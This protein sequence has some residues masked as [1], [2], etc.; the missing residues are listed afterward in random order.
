MD[1]FDRL[2]ENKVVE[3]SGM[4]RGC[5]EESYAG[6]LVR[7]LKYPSLIG[8][9]LK[10]YCAKVADKLKEMLLN[11]DSENANL[12]SESDQMELIFQIFKLLVIGGPLNQNDANITRYFE[13]TKKVYKDLLSVFKSSDTQEIK[14]A[15]S[16]FRIVSFEGV[17]LHGSSE[18]CA[19]LMIVNVDPVKKTVLLLK[20]TFVSFW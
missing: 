8:I 11:S 1:F 3:P 2:R 19:N 6:I 7:K 14:V 13:I 10:Y 18:H 15:N 9:K 12:F 16:V 5:Y 4:I 20:N 17:E